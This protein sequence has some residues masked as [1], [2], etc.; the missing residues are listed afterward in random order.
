MIPSLRA[1]FKETLDD[2]FLVDRTLPRTVVSL[3][4]RPGQLTSDWLAGQR[5]RY[6]RPLRLYMLCAVPLFLMWSFQ[7]Q[8][9]SLFGDILQGWMAGTDA[10]LMITVQ[11]LW[12]LP[13]VAS[14]VLSLHIH[15]FLMLLTSVL[16]G[17]KL[18][19]GGFPEGLAVNLGTGVGLLYVMVLVSAGPL[20][21]DRAVTRWHL[22][23]PT[24]KLWPSKL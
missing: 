1:W 14:L 4:T 5:V 12:S 21:L 6:L 8:P 10:G 7:T 15:A 24:I 3:L 20:T 2:L 16:L 18:A 22:C 17:L 11:A 9:Q 19:L 13:I 23:F